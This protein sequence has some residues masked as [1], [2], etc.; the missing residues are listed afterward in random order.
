MKTSTTVTAV[1]SSVPPNRRQPLRQARTNPARTAAN[2]IRPFGGRGSFGGAQDTQQTTH[3][4]PGFF[5][6]ITHFTDSITALPKEMVRHYTLLKEVDA[7]TYG[8]EEMLGQFVTTALNTPAPPRKV[9]TTLPQVNDETRSTTGTAVS[10]AGSVSDGTAALNLGQVEATLQP[11]AQADPNTSDIP[12]RA[13]FRDLRI[14]A[15]EMLMTLDE[16][17]HL[18]STANETLN[19]QLARCESSFKHSDA[20]ISEEARYGI[21]NHWAYSTEKTVEK[22]GTTAGERTRRDVAAAN[23]LAAAAAALNGEDVAALRSESRREA[24]AARKQ[25]NQRADSEFDDGRGAVQSGAKR[26]QGNTKSRKAA[27]AGLSVNGAGVGLGV[28]NGAASTAAGASTKRRKIEKPFTGLTNGG[29][30]IERALSSVYGANGGAARGAAGSPRSTPAVEVTKKRVR[31]AAATNGTARKRTNT[32]ASAANSPQMASSPVVS[33]FTAVKANSPAPGVTQRAQPAR[34][35]QNSSQSIL[36]DARQRRPS[37]ASNKG[38][39]GNGLYGTAADVDKVAGL[40]GRSVGDIK[41]SMKEAVNAKGEHLV[42]DTG[43]GEGDMRGG[44][45][46]GSRGQ[47][48]SLKRE[49]TIENGEG[50]KRTERLPSIST[51]TRNGGKTSKTSTPTAASFPEPQRARS[52]RAT[53]TTVK[54]SHKKGAGLAAQLAAAAA[55]EDDGSSMQGDDEDDEDG[56]EPRYCYCNQVSYGEMVACDMD[57]CPREW[58]HLDCV[59][60]TKAPTKNAKWYCDECKENLKKGKFAGGR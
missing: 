40:T 1:E 41:S 35:R 8:P 11:E 51:S 9:P 49:E 34:A 57:S 17:N 53:E 56:E 37:S 26:A 43:D 30:T 39:N 27:E 45:L 18:I 12:R 47:D 7:K 2:G 5:P 14:V 31:S 42:E 59:G 25:R 58:F 54:R 22:K 23:S 38:A 52:S 29:A 55:V 44:L 16:K 13:L 19:K 28:A 20:E 48:R 21:L 46:V 36:Q 6:A 33:S 10:I 15:Q 60:L 32:N 4:A 24:L 50:T 3:A